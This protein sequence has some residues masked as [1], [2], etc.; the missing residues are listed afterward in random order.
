MAQK[1]YK[2]RHDNVAKVVHKELAGKCGFQRTDK[3]YDHVPE[4]A[5]LDDEGYKIL[6][7]FNIQTDHGVDHGVED[8]I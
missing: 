4:G 7:N 5:V 6:W 3:W 8:L 2:K 1:E